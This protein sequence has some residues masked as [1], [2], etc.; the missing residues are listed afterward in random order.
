MNMSLVYFYFFCVRFWELLYWSFYDWYLNLPMIGF[1]WSTVFQTWQPKGRC[2]WRWL[3]VPESM[4]DEPPVSSTVFSGNIL[5]RRGPGR[6]VKKLGL[7]DL[8]KTTSCRN[9]SLAQLLRLQMKETTSNKTPVRTLIQDMVQ[10]CF[11]PAYQQS[12]SMI[13]MAWSLA[14]TVYDHVGCANTSKW[15]E[16]KPC[17]KS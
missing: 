14:S 15:N 12:A 17:S 5:W 9:I 10:T 4:A 1:S 11:Y 13:P 8:N 16:M 6:S 3:P 7:K 2:R